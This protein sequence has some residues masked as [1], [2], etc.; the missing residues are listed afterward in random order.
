[1]YKNR[2]PENAEK[3]LMEGL[4]FTQF[5]DGYTSNYRLIFVYHSIGEPFHSIVKGHNLDFIKLTASKSLGDNFED[6]SHND[7]LN[8][9]I[10]KLIDDFR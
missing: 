1:M 6:H 8:E 5:L 2:E 3:A 4:L 10:K 9:I 7:Y